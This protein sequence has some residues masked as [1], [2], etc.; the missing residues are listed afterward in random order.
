MYPGNALKIS[1]IDMLEIYLVS[2]L[3]DQFLC[4]FINECQLQACARWVMLNASPSLV[5]DAV[6]DSLSCVIHDQSYEGAMVIFDP[7]KSVLENIHSMRSE[8]SSCSTEPCLN[9]RMGTT[10]VGA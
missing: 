3:N 1:L 4:R 8:C 2:K 9:S 6:R 5:W 7:I 10:L